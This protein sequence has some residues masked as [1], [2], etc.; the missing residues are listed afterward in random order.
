MAAPLIAVL[1]DYGTL[2]PYV[3]VVKGVIARLLP[4]A[5]VIDLSHEVPP[6]D[7]RVGAFRLWQSVPYFPEGT[8]FLAVV[9]PGVGTARRALAAAW[10]GYICVAP[11]NGLLTYLFVNRPPTAIHALASASH[12]LPVVSATFHGR[13]IFAPA[14]A[15]LARGEPIE[16]LGPRIVDPVLFPLPL[17]QADE[18]RVVRGVV[19]HADRFGNWI[20]SVGRLVADGDQWMLEPWLPGCRRLRMPRAGA[21]V[22][23]PDGNVLPLRTT[24]AEVEEGS[25]LAYVGSSGLIEI[26]VNRGRAADLLPGLQGQSV[27]LLLPE[28]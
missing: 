5:H 28:G 21:S 17:L 9:D 6:G 14:A 26:A 7:I 11:D 24:F 4:E 19:L 18:D 20:S 1:T 27:S 22:R 13:D 23:L 2:D 10:P 16:R 8:V 12:R 15:H 3:G 25:L